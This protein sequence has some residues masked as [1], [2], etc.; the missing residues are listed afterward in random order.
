MS[1]AVVLLA[2]GLA[3]GLAPC[4]FELRVVAAV[5]IAGVPIAVSAAELTAACGWLVLAVLSV[6]AAASLPAP[7]A[8]VVSAGS[9]VELVEGV[10]VGEVK[11]EVDVGS[12]DG[13]G[14][15]EPGE[16][17]FE[18]GGLEKWP[19]GLRVFLQSGDVVELPGWLDEGTADPEPSGFRCPG[20]TGVV[21]P[22]P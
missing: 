16:L 13:D 18:L 20:P 14:D 6:P 22:E 12:G 21:G 11:E 15:G 5:L 7:V 3:E 10:G 2:H 9:G 4:R 1:A 19:F 17:L 8:A